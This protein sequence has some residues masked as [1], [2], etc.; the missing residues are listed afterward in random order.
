MFRMPSLISL[1]FCLV[2][3]LES[4]IFNSINAK[5]ALIKI[6]A[7]NAFKRSQLKIEIP[8]EEKTHTQKK[9]L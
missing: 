5:N 8:E 4:Q 6:N 1:T 9:K 3:L 7:K 2:F